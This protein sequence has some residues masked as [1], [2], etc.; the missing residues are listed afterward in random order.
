MRHKSEKVNKNPEAQSVYLKKFHR[1]KTKE[2]GLKEFT[3][4]ASG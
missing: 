4:S 3:A 2:K 1:R